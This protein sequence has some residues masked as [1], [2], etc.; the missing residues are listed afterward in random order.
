MSTYYFLPWV[1]SGMAQL[2]TTP[3]L[4]DNT[5]PD[6]K[7]GGVLL[8][9]TVT[10]NGKQVEP[11]GTGPPQLY[12]PGDVVGI[13]VREI[14]R[15]GP[16]HL[17]PDY[18]PERFAFIEFDRPDFPWL[19]TPGTQSKDRLRP[20]LVLV[21]VEKSKATITPPTD[22]RLPVLSCPI[23][24]LPPTLDES[25]AWAHAVYAG[26]LGQNPDAATVATR[27]K[28]DPQD[29]NL[30]RLLCPR[31]LVAHIPYEACLVPAFEAGRKAGLG[32]EFDP[33]REALAH[34]EFKKDDEVKLPVYYHWSFSTGDEDQFIKLAQQLQ[35]LS[36]EEEEA[37]LEG[38]AGEMDIS[39]P[40][41]GMEKS[42]AR[43]TVSIPSALR[44]STDETSSS[45]SNLPPGF[46]KEALRVL[47]TTPPETKDEMTPLPLPTYGSW[48]APPHEVSAQL[49]THKWL[50]TLNLD[51]RYRVAA[52]LG[53]SIIQKEQEHI[54]AAVWRE[55]GEL[56]AANELLQRKQL[57]CCVTDSIHKKRLQALTP[58]AFLQMTEPAPLPAN[59]PL[60]S[61]KGGFR[62]LSHTQ[63]NGERGRSRDAVAKAGTSAQSAQQADESLTS[64]AAAVLAD[65]PVAYYR[66]NES[67]GS[68][69]VRDSSGNDNHSVQVEGGVTFGSPGR[70]EGDAAAKFDGTSGRIVVHNSDSLNPSFVTM[71]A[72][73]RWMGPHPADPTI[74][75]RILEKSSYSTLAQYG[76][77]IDPDGRVLAQLRPSTDHVEVHA[78]SNTRIDH[79]VLVH[80]SATYDGLTI[81]IYINGVLDSEH[82]APGRI[83]PQQPTQGNLIEA[84]LG[85]GNQAQA[86]RP[87]PFHGLIDEVAIYDRA[88]SADRIQ[89]HALAARPL[90]PLE[91]VA[92]I[93]QFRRMT[94][95]GRAWSLKGTI[96]DYDPD[97]IAPP[98]GVREGDRPVS[99]DSLSKR[100]PRVAKAAG[101]DASHLD[102]LK[103]DWLTQTEPR[104]TFAADVAHRVRRPSQPRL[105]KSVSQEE[106]FQQHG[107][108]GPFT[109]APSF[110]NP[111]Y[112][113]LR[114]QFPEMLLP[115]LNKIPNDR[116]TTLSVDAPFIEGYMVGLN[117]ELSREFLWREF[118][119]MLNVTYF[120]QFWEVGGA[121]N[122]QAPD[123]SAPIGD[124]ENV[125]DGKPLDLGNHLAPGRGGDLTFLL[126]RS[127]LVIRY[128]NALIYARKKGSDGNVDPASA[129]LLPVLRFSPITGVALLG[130]SLEVTKD[131]PP[132]NI[133]YKFFIEE[134]F[135]EP[136]MGDPDAPDGAYISFAS[137]GQTSAEIAGKI[138]LERFY[139]E[140]KVM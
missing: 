51:P 124:W 58:Y 4:G 66:F 137:K 100:S 79:N 7:S 47:L 9:V 23:K 73:I 72:V 71:E 28:D 2:I 138:L 121:K 87:R 111:M 75:Q 27:L 74:S 128:P 41:N 126:I 20:W 114:D 85:L 89:T 104:T 113:P 24:E 98:P 122:S 22:N 32:E 52:A 96:S 25:W 90:T 118:P 40:G 132:N 43:L 11:E 18:P 30:S 1:R 3:D 117:H 35:P 120:R 36:V 133:P 39:D 106:R 64:F 13:D 68:T 8:P 115:G 21:V 70:G 46:N 139:R 37:A 83:N 38:I 82:S 105:T 5:L 55:V 123:L 33:N 78:Y 125:K 102:D 49:K 92:I 94:R 60:N 107:E 110:S 95:A 62:Q 91:Q 129:P 17:T 65:Q 31:K 88:L 81:R 101:T 130:F 86:S 127:E 44:I 135:T 26:D 99:G 140:I 19:F 69:T 14:I 48:H 29:R 93:P 15:T 119:T 42:R 12:G 54:V 67:Q 57:A 50:E 16:L 63:L 77:N 116:A 34:W 131:P 108:L 61:A 45:A 112:E 6:V 80:I 84:G 76:L 109:Y 134:H 136:Y 103:R 56:Q 97:L 59:D 10:L 53:T